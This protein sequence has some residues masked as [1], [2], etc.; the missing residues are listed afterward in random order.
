MMVTKVRAVIAAATVAGALLLG[1]GSAS[2]AVPTDDPTASA[3]TDD[4]PYHVYGDCVVFPGDDPTDYIVVC[5]PEVSSGGGALVR[6]FEDGSATYSDGMVF[7]PDTIQ[8]RYGTPVV[9]G[10]VSYV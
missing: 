10:G 1:G 3:M 7:D 6:T 5:V 2:A 4:S 8:F 9:T